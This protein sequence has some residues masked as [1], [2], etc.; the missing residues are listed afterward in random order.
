MS[1]ETTCFE[2]GSKL[3]LAL[4]SA[5]SKSDE[6]TVLSSILVGKDCVRVIGP[7]ISVHFGSEQKEKMK[8]RATDH[9]SVLLHC[10][11]ASVYSR[12]VQTDAWD[13][14]YDPV[15][16]EMLTYEDDPI[17]QPVRDTPSSEYVISTDAMKALAKIAAAVDCSNVRFFKR[18][19]AI[20]WKIAVEPSLFAVPNLCL[21]GTVN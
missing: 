6:P 4:L 9:R 7:H 10:Y 19:D 8:F 11:E 17:Q 3:A 20:V 13:S 21:H 12:E 18:G 16:G 2:M 14:I 15:N 1:E 5:A